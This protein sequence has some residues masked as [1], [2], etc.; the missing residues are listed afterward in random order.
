M[1]LPLEVTTFAALTFKFNLPP[2]LTP[3]LLFSVKVP[4]AVKFKVAA[5]VLLVA[6][7]VM[8]LV[9]TMLPP[10]PVLVVPA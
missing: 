2:A 10:V 8:A 7:A 5:E 4:V 3:M 6:A 9:T 1:L